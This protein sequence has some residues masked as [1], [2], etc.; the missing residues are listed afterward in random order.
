MRVFSTATAPL[1][2]APWALVF[3]L[4]CG[5]AGPVSEVCGTPGMEEA[6]ECLCPDPASDFDCDGVAATSD[7]DDLDP[8]LGAQAKDMD[9]DGVPTEFDCNDNDEE[10][11][12]SNEGDSDCDGVATEVDCDDEDPDVISSSADDQDCDGL[13]TEVDCDDTDSGNT[14]SNANDAD[15]D[16]LATDIDCNDGDPNKTASSEFDHD[17]DGVHTSDDC[18]DDDD[19][20]TDVC[21]ACTGEYSFIAGLGPEQLNVLSTCSSLDGSLS[22]AEFPA[23]ALEGLRNLIHVS[24]DFQL[25]MLTG[26][27]DLSSLDR[28]REVGGD[29]D[30]RVMPDLADISALSGMKAVGG[31]VTFWSNGNL[32]QSDVDAFLSGGVSYSGEGM[33]GYNDDGC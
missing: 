7:C 1:A 33:I 32:C 31:D 18:D 11:V 19:Q 29:L 2:S 13:P 26:L 9:C 4:A 8:D 27:S 14:T 16:G 6:P 20:N 24:G 10:N 5:G 25:M 17:C 15:C 23:S 12:A 30:I 21:M 22:L 3:L 28:L